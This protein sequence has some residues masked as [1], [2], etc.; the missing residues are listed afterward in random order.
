MDLNLLKAKE[1]T[2]GDKIRNLKSVV[3]AYSGGVDSSLLAYYARKALG[4]KALIVIAISPSLA[5][6]E[7]D[8]AREQGKQFNWDVL[9]TN[10]DEVE[11]PEY[12]ANNEM[13]CYFC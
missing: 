9:E 3:I 13:R 11:N 7:L 1:I 12:K 6:S 2:L 4:T 5:K 8:F 10:T